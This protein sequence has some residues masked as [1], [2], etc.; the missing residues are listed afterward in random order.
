MTKTTKILDKF[1]SYAGVISAIVLII[2]S[3]LVTYDAGMRYLFSEGSIALQEIE[4]HLYDIVFLLGISYALRHKK[5][6][7]V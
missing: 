3:L 7:R 5:H 6:V 1:S 4:W 2:L